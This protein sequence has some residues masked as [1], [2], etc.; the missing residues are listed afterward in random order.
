[1]SLS[2]NPA[3]PMDYRA[4]NRRR[5]LCVFPRYVHSFGT[6]A[7]A[8]PLMG[9][10]AFMPPQ[11]LLIIA[12]SLPS[13][14]EVR[15]V[16]ENVRPV[17]DADLQWADAV[18]MS[19]MHVQHPH[20]TGINRRAHAFGKIT[21]LGG[22]SVSAC[23]EWYPDV[24]L[25]H[26]GEIGDATRALI[27]RLDRS[28]DRPATQEIYR[29]EERLPLTEF[30]LPAYH[31]IDLR[32][33]FMA[34]V[35]FSSGCPYRCEFCDIPAL[36][37]R[38]PR[39]K[40]PQQ[41]TAELDAMLTRGNPGAVYFVDDNFI[42]N[43]KAAMALLK[44]LVRWQQERG[45]PITFACEATLN[46]AQVPE[47]LELMREAGF[48][49]VFCGIETPE[50]NALRSIHKEQNLRQPILDAVATFN[51]YGIE[52]VSGIILG[53]DTDTPST[54]RRIQEFITVSRIPLLTINILH[55]LPKTPLWQ[56][57][58]AEGR[59]L[60]HSQQESNIQFLLPYETVVGMW[61]DCVT[62][63]YT[64]EAIYARFAYQI[65][66]TYPNRKR[67]PATRARVNLANIRRGLSILLRLFWHVGIRSDY[68]R[69]FWQMA[70]PRLLRL[71]IE[72]VIHVA[73]VSH[74]LI[75][76]ARECAAGQA[77]KC[78]YSPQRIGALSQSQM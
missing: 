17:T 11:G 65:Q 47:A 59:L 18:L 34:S 55:A 33:Y 64:P 26:I 49:T 36:Y 14:W 68:R 23:P 12:A 41:V 50:E 24:D 70:L 46:L 67:L 45:Y 8:F 7:H 20:I 30:P 69:L 35:Q 53:L 4:H 63:V 51:R 27:E 9:V 52:V 77:E 19:S 39:L 75:L 21:V 76:F 71:D 31:H 72:R 15:F 62:R 58:E 29:T 10:R 66:H 2:D 43:R 78:F 61:L 54:G 48:T 73:V 6:F 25:L 5:I 3:C 56:R 16:D 60:F 42:G 74:H 38:N 13:E 28:A 22:P 37:G 44:E 32:H 40:S 1:M 57:L